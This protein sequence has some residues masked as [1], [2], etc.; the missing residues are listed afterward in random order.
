[1]APKGQE[2]LPEVREDVPEIRPAL[3]TTSAVTGIA[4]PDTQA[5]AVAASPEAEKALYDRAF[6]S[7]KDLKYADAAEQ[8][9][10]FLGQ[11][12]S[13]DYAD[14]AQYWLG[15]SYYVTRNYDIALKAFQDLMDRYPESSKVPDALLKVGYT[16]YELEQWDSARAALTQ[17]QESYPDTTLDRLAESRLRSMRM[18]GHY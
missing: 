11:Y 16:H 14:N 17:V 12:P 3:D 5:R 7:L 9:Q 1:M 8:F 10:I 13:S 18:E 4:T 6:Q 15:E 2:Y